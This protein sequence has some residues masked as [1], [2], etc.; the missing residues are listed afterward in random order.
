MISP[1]F[2]DPPRYA[3]YRCTGPVSPLVAD[4]SAH[5]LGLWGVMT[6]AL[7]TW[8]PSAQNPPSPDVSMKC[9]STG[10]LEESVLSS[11]TLTVPGPGSVSSGA[12][13][14]GAGSQE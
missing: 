12:E 9:E 14:N 11:T 10:W 6:L 13:V 3:A 2:P 8:S 7:C 4:M 5:Q 1:T